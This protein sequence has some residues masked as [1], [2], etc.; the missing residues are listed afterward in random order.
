MD[1]GIML[2]VF[3]WPFNYLDSILTSC[4]LWVC[5]VL[6]GA[7]C[8]VLDVHSRH[9]ADIDLVMPFDS[10]TWSVLTRIVSFRICKA[11]PVHLL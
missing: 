8:M 3:W 11:N 4:G 5:V 10:Q 7:R 2:C 1:L 6:Q 9:L